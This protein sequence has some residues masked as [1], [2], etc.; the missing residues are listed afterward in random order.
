MLSALEVLESE[1]ELLGEDDYSDDNSTNSKRNLQLIHSD[2]CEPMSAESI[3][4]NTYFITFI[5]DFLR[6]CAVCFPKN[7]SEVSSKV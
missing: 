7:K 1:N 6:C 2:V 5:D 3:G 4:G